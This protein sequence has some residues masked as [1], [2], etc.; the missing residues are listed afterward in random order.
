MK[1]KT[2]AGIV[3]AVIL[4][5]YTVLTFALPFA[6]NAVLWISYIFSVVAVAAQL[7][8]LKVAFCRETTVKSRFYGFPVANLGVI[9]LI[10]QLVL[11]LIFM[12][13]AELVP[14]WLPLVVYVVLLGAA[15]VGF[16][17]ADAMRDEVERQ[18]TK[19]KCDVSAMRSLQSRANALFGQ[20]EQEALTA[21]VRKLADNLRY[22]DP[23]SSDA[24]AEQ[25][26]Q[27]AALMDELENAVSDGETDAAL[28]LCKRMTAVLI[29]R[30]RLC[31][32]NK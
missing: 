20:C 13:L 4:A 29:E 28:T 8:V 27:L 14:L 31:K 6:K 24:I 16:I 7:Y 21:A 23:I 15:A 11:G 18:D 25:E 32:L 26:K 10:V 30:N 12:A 19:L 9:Y 1:N 17:A 5:V 22:S 3:L 2:R